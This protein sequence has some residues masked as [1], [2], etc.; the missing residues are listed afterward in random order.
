MVRNLPMWRCIRVVSIF[1]KRGEKTIK[2]QVDCSHLRKLSQWNV[3]CCP[4][5]NL[6]EPLKHQRNRGHFCFALFCWQ[7]PSGFGTPN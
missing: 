2:K 5:D 7:P 4:I 3:G 1:V 6:R